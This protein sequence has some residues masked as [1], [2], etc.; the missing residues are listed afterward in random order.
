[1]SG[2]QFQCPLKFVAG[3]YYVHAD[4][5]ASLP[6][7]H[8]ARL[9]AAE[10]LAKIARTER[11]NV[12]RFD[13]SGDEVSLLNYPKFFEDAFPALEESWHVDLAASRVSYRTY[14]DSLNPPILHRKELMLAED[15]PRRPEFQ[16]LTEAAEAIGL[17]QDPTRVGFRES[18]LR[19]VRE[20][21]YQIVGHE[22]I[23]IAN[24]DT[25]TAPGESK[26]NGSSIARHLT[27][28]VRHGFSAPVQALTRYGLINP[29]VEVLDYGCGRGDG[30]SWL[31]G[32]R[33]SGIWVGPALRARRA[34]A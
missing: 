3:H 11:F 19:L 26:I 1:M 24:D 10:S 21:G 20:S 23:P 28:L 32:K 31:N 30:R 4:A 29:S 8:L 9:S 13:R 17:F 18:W 33:N 12:V 16:A 22:L 27:A 25:T 2:S 15:Q 5:F 7:D 6:T 14:R 34:E